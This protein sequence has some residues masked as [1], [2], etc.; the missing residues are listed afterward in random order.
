MQNISRA[1]WLGSLELHMNTHQLRITL[2]TCPV[3]YF[4]GSCHSGAHVRK[5]LVPCSSNMATSNTS[6][7]LFSI[8]PPTEINNS[9][10]TYSIAI[11][12]IILGFITTLVVAARLAYRFWKK[13]AGLDDYAIILALVRSSFQPS[14]RCCARFQVP[15]DTLI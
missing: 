13:S 6:S 2:P 7:S 4:A 10:K 1:G 8:P 14:I 12:C 9:H 3:S 15:A 5:F 11:A